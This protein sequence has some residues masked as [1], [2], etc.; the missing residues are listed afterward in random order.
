MHTARYQYRDELGTPV[1][2]ASS[3]A[4]V[5]SIHFVHRLHT[6]HPLRSPSST[7]SSTSFITAASSTTLSSIVT[8]VDN[9]VCFVYYCGFARSPLQLCLPPSPALSIAS[10]HIPSPSSIAT[11]YFSIFSFYR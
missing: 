5:R 8:I 6:L 10:F 9:L 2:T 7:T 1:R 11:S 3:T 4:F